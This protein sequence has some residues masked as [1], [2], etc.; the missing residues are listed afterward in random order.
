MQNDAGQSIHQYSQKGQKTGRVIAGGGGSGDAADDGQSA[1]R[2][3]GVGSKG[4]D[5]IELERAAA[6]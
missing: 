1:G 6:R 5:D 2:A 4:A 3:G